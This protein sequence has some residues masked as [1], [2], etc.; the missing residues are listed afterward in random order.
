MG[1]SAPDFIDEMLAKVV[2]IEI[3]IASITG[4]SKLSQN[5]EAR[6]RLDA[7]DRLDAKGQAE[8]AQAMRQTV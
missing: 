4:K 2:G 8:L 3:E 7:A 6:D 1:D 5:K